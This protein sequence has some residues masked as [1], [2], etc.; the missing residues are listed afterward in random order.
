MLLEGQWK[1]S[2]EFNKKLNYLYTELN[3]NFEALNTH[4]KK[5]NIRV[6]QIAETGKRHERFLHGTLNTVKNTLSTPLW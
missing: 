4:V 5:M 6:Q 3:G 2:D 1:M